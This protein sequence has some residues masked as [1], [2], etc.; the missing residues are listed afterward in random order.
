MICRNCGAT[1]EIV[2]CDLGAQALANSYLRSEDLDKPETFYPLKPVICPECRLVQLPPLVAPEEIFRDYAFF[3]GQ[4]Q[5]WMKHCEQF[6]IHILVDRLCRVERVLEIASNDGVLLEQFK[7]H[8]CKVLG[9]EPARNIA[10]QAQF[11]GT[12]T[13]P[14]F[15]GVA[16]AQ[17]LRTSGYS[18]DLIVANNV[19]AH[20]PD[21]DDFLGGVRLLM[22]DNTVATFEVPHLAKLIES[23]AWDC[24]YHEHYSTFGFVTIQRVFAMRGLR[25]FDV[26]ELDVHGGSLRVYVCLEGSSVHPTNAAP[27]QLSRWEQEHGFWDVSTL[28]EFA[29]RPP[30]TKCKTMMALSVFREAGLTIAGYGAPAKGST[31][32]NYCG[33]GPETI[34]FIVD[35]TPAKQRRF[36]PG[37]RIPILPIE[38]LQ[39]RKPDVIWILPHNWETEIREKIERDC[40]WHPTVICRP[41]LTSQI[42]VS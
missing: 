17:R 41:W 14:E 38:A 11:C 33:F 3:S 20:C 12:P 19:L 39:E 1:A 6:A 36:M 18:P 2:F 35:S 31:F 32:L 29:K 7:H 16:L 4:S 30:E 13:I 8:G 23:D 28:A 34:E 42:A 21:F 25:V 10:W 24:L 40:D 37:S 15:F 26:E 5:S 27:A 9:V 22:T